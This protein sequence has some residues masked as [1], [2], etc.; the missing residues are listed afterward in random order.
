MATTTQYAKHPTKPRQRRRCTAQERLARGRRQVRHAAAVVE[1][2]LYD[3]GLPEHLTTEI[4]GRLQSQKKLLGKIFGVMGPPLFGC[5]TNA[6]RGYAHA[7]PG[8]LAE[9]ARRPDYGRRGAA[10]HAGQ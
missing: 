3:L 2:A 9:S 5:R 7:A 8:W 6:E 4:E 10:C 1:Q